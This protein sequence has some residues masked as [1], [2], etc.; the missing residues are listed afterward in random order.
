[1]QVCYFTG[2]MRKVDWQ[3]HSEHRKPTVVATLSLDTL[4]IRGLPSSTRPDWRGRVQGKEHASFGQAG[5]YRRQN[6]NGFSRYF[7]QTAT[8]TCGDR[9][10]GEGKGMTVRIWESERNGG[11]QGAAYFPRH[12]TLLLKPHRLFRKRMECSWNT[13]LFQHRKMW[14]W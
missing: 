11:R 1:M 6:P 12:S 13:P 4:S 9:R 14:H 8:G 3:Q 5:S 2:D 10:G 7:M